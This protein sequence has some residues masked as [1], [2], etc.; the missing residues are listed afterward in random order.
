M[1]EGGGVY[2]DLA[3][4]RSDSIKGWPSTDDCHTLG[5]AALGPTPCIDLLAV[6]HEPSAAG[7][8]CTGWYPLVLVTTYSVL[9]RLVGLEGFEVFVNVLIFA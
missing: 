4:S 5:A 1:R 8:L 3:Q 7:A 2:G 6:I 9:R